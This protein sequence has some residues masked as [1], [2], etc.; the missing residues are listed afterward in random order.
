VIDF[1]VNTA[2]RDRAVGE[3]VTIAFGGETERTVP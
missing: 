1:R 2:S 3:H